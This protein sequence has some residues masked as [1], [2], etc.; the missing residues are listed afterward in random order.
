MTPL[1]DLAQLWAAT[2]GDS[3]IAVAILDGPVDVGHPS[4]AKARLERLPTLT[5]GTVDGSWASRHGTHIT[6]LVFGQHDGPV[7]GVAPGC[8]GLLLPI[9]APAAKAPPPPCTQLDLARAISQAL[10]A[11]AQVINISG[12]EFTPGGQAHPL[13][14]DVV[15]ECERL[16]CLIVAATGNDGCA[17]PHVPAAVDSVLAVGAMDD[18]GEPLRSSNWGGSYQYQGILAPGA[19]LLGAQPGGGTTRLTG[20]SG[21]TAIVSGVVALLLSLQLRRG[22]RPDARAVRQALLQTAV[23]CRTRP[24]RDCD[25]L[26][27]GRLN[28]SGAIEYLFKGPTPMSLPTDS[29]AG[30]LNPA[31]QEG[32]ASEAPLL[33]PPPGSSAAVQPSAC[34]CS[35]RPTQL[36]YALGY[37]SYDLISEARQDALRQKII[38]DWRI[39][40]RR[41]QP[42]EGGGAGTP[43][44]ERS[45]PGDNRQ[46]IAHLEY[47]PT[48]AASVEWIL[49]L[50]GTPIYAIRP[51]GPFAA[52]VYTELRDFFKSQFE[53]GVERI[54]VPGVLSGQ[55][56]LSTGQTVPIVVP[57]L[58]G[59]YSWS[60]AELVKVVL[61]APPSPTATAAEKKEY[62]DKTA[63]V[64]NFLDRVYHGL[65]NLGLLPQDRALN[66]AATNAFNVERMFESAVKDNMELDSIK[67]TRSPVSRPN[68]DC[69]DIEVYFFYPERQVQTVRKVYRFTIDVSDI[70]PVTIGPMHSWYTR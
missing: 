41:R 22:I 24:A 63:G 46:W 12:G 21:A 15:Q 2:L 68:S 39:E 3:R 30:S 38:A 60:T 10:A 61:G 19:G 34:G 33:P 43:P 32:A 16:G 53:E 70:V 52:A 48:D 1:L 28:L 8:R 26:L 40:S 9:F 42:N 69:W 11:G 51:D 44:V 47:K 67:V 64:K 17:C 56:R 37:L 29:L 55:A 58:R 6:S 59:M 20:T 45:N 25:R 36:V 66:Y 50:D 4:L 18:R 57:E 7:K 14:A 65:R 31:P 13:L 49:L 5:P 23:D 27:V 54:S 35:A 62:E